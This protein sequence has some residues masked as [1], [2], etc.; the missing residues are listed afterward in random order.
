MKGINDSLRMSPIHSGCH[1]FLK[2]DNFCGAS[3]TDSSPNVNLLRL[4]EL[5]LHL[6]WCS[7]PVK[8]L[9]TVVFQLHSGFVRKNDV[10]DIFLLQQVLFAPLYSFEILLSRIAR[11]YL[12][13]PNVH[14]RS[15]LALARVHSEYLMALPQNLS[16]IMSIRSLAVC[17]SFDMASSINR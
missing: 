13:I 8:T 5:V 12:A 14:P 15:C 10:V 1:D 16:C 4:I 3:L 6:P 11:Q 7:S 9:S 17:S 2:D